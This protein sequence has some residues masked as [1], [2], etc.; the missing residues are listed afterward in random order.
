M[1]AVTYAKYIKVADLFDLGPNFVN[2]PSGYQGD[3]RSSSTDITPIKFNSAEKKTNQQI[4]YSCYHNSK[5]Y[6]GPVLDKTQK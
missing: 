1:T 6:K 5:K 2:P 4:Q 3:P